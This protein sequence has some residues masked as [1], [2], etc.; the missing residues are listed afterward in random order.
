M[1]SEARA[2]SESF[3]LH[4]LLTVAMI[5]MAG[6]FKPPSPAIRLDSC[7]LEQA[8]APAPK[9]ETQQKAALGAAPVQAPPVASP[10]PPVPE[11]QAKV[12][13]AIV[14]PP[15][16]KPVLAKIKPAPPKPIEPKA[17]EV[18]AIVPTPVP[19][20][21]TLSATESSTEET[22]AAVETPERSGQAASTNASATATAGVKSPGQGSARA[23]AGAGETTVA[24]GEEY[25]RANFGAIRDSIL[26]HLRYPMLARR[27][28][29]SGQVEVAFMIAPDGSV[30]ELRIRTSSGFPVLDDQ[31][32]AAIRRSAPFTPPPRMAALLVMPVTFQLN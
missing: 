18:A 1:I 27:Q 9:A 23:G 8:A 26:G 29:W 21:A 28:G 11:P 30:D 10:T 25:R 16:P 15:K 22:L 13:T 12:Q 5:A 20:P 31:A 4:V 6:S 2:I 32:L 7:M 14:P 19:A 17:P 24:A 3:M